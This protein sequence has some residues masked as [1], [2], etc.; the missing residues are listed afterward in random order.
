LPATLPRFSSDDAPLSVSGIHARPAAG[1]LG[2][3]LG[4]LLGEGGF[5]KV[6]AARRDEDGAPAAIKIG[7]AQG[8][9]LIERFRRE[10]SALARI[11]PPHVAR[12]YQFGQLADGRPFI[13]MERLFGR[14]LSM[15]L[16]ELKAQPDLSWTVQRA[17]AIAGALAVAHAHGITH[18]DLKPANIFI[19]QPE[20]RAILIDFGLARS[21]FEANDA[22]TELTRPGVVVGTPAYLAPEQIR[23]DPMIDARA[24]VYAFG[25][26]LFELLTLRNPFVGEVGAV[27]LGH[28]ALR[29]PHPS[30]LVPVSAE[31]D[32]LT[33]AC[34]AKDPARRPSIAEI[35]C[36]LAEMGAATSQPTPS[37][38]TPSG[39]GGRL[40]AEAGLP[41]V[42]LVA[43]TSHAAPLIVAAVT[44]CGGLVVRRR[45][46]RYVSI[47]PAES[48]EPSSAALAAARDLVEHHGARAALHLADIT[49]RRN[50]QDP[51]AVYGAPV[52]HPEEWLPAEPWAGLW[53]SAEIEQLLGEPGHSARAF[54]M[55]TDTA[56]PLVGRDDVL[57]ALAESAARAF[58]GTC[59][60]LFTLLGDNG[61]GKS[62]IA[63]VA[64]DVARSA[65]KE[66]RILSLRAAPHGP[67]EGGYAKETWAL[68]RWIRQGAPEDT[69]PARRNFVRALADRLSR[70]ARELPLVVILDDAHRADDV[71]LDAL[72]YATLDGSG[73]R[74]WVVVVAHPRFFASR[75][76]WGA[77]TQRHDR[78]SLSPLDEDAGMALASWLLRPADYLPMET[79]RR[80][81]DFAGGNPACLVDLVRSLAR[82]RAVRQRRNGRGYDV[83]MEVL[84]SLPPSPTRQWLAVRRLAELPATLAALARI[85][86]VL[87]P[88]FTE[89][90]LAVV[91]EGLDRAGGAGSPLDAGVGL[92]A[93]AAAEI[94]APAA[95]DRWS[96]PSA[97]LQEAIEALVDPAHRAEIHRQALSYWRARGSSAGRALAVARHAAGCGGR[98]EAAWAL[99]HLGK[100]ALS[101][102]RYVEADLR[103]SSA[104]S[105]LGAEDSPLRACALADRGRARYRIHRVR[106]AREDFAAA[107]SLAEESGDAFRKAEILLEDA[108]ALDW[109]RQFDT[110]AWRVEE[111]RSIVKALGDPRLA[112]RLEVAEGRTLHRRKETQ[113]S[114]AR[115]ERASADALSLADHESLVIAWLL[116]SF[117]LASIGRLEEAERKFSEVIALAD[118]TGDLPH[119]G[120][121]YSNRVALWTARGLPD[122]AIQDLHHVVALAREIGNPWLEHAAAYNVAL[123]LYGSDAQTE[124]LA[125]ARRACLL[126]DR[127]VETPIPGAPLLLSEI[128]LMLEQYEE[129]A[130]IAEAMGASALRLDP[131]DIPCQKMVELVLSDLGALVTAPAEGG[132]EQAMR[133]AEEN[134]FSIEGELKLLY[135]RARMAR[136]GG[137]LEEARSAL[138]TAR[139]R[140]AGCAMWRS[141]FEALEAELAEAQSADRDGSL[142]ARG[143][144]SERAVGALG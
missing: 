136:R 95:R 63:G 111:A 3:T 134:G 17:D 99:L 96:F 50:G 37:T 127:A 81:A 89:E 78:A 49:V 4:E 14:T 138:A 47:F 1:L 48:E 84:A 51:P 32:E 120:A 80:L 11:G 100:E 72:E 59:P 43:E 10:A 133:L 29:P 102:H 110:S 23:C 9:V 143:A 97:V 68:L 109:D 73:V 107:L 129:A 12:L 33:L 70:Q 76:R 104:L 60:G 21:S 36:A 53:F 22:R 94:V 135:W 42:L 105:L 103:Y 82:A 26:I 67:P 6:W 16:L 77:R 93:L 128:L 5:A 40:V 31:F 19:T 65:A 140:R 101:R 118:A 55:T 98:A 20:D 35:R 132:W 92:T 62:R 75:P 116:L 122:R 61:L 142:E 121:A 83:A 28:L 13:A 41:T 27:E 85:C 88:A 7:H 137:R 44:G 56:P 8:A 45:G 86:A 46:H 64:V 130:R 139:R 91:L 113:A 125:L 69:L 141:R 66:A 114:I 124:A 90:E 54:E 79:L 58:D 25:V 108:T 112:L 30:E 38:V 2:F 71:L 15:E 126:A 123:M 39:R 106:E 131:E 24:D 119:L 57:A 117:Q 74:L 18:R 115:L 87:G 52:N 34:L 144:P